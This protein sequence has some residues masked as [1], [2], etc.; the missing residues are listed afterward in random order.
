MSTHKFNDRWL[1]ERVVFPDSRVAADAVLSLYQDKTV[2][3]SHT[4]N[5]T[6]YAIV[7]DRA[8]A[9]RYDASIEQNL[10]TEFGLGLDQLASHHHEERLGKLKTAWSFNHC[11]ALQSWAEHLLSRPF[12]RPLIVRFDAH[13][14]LAAPMVGVTEAKGVFTAPVGGST[15]DLNDTSTIEEFVLRGF[16]G[17][18]SFIAPIL[19]TLPELDIVHVAQDHETAPEEFELVAEQTIETMFTGRRLCRPGVRLGP[20]SPQARFRYTRTSDAARALD[21]AAGRDHILDIDLDYFCNAFDNRKPLAHAM[22]QDA[23]RDETERL[24]DNFQRALTAS[25][26]V[27]S[28]VTLAL[29]PGFFPS[30]YW[31]ATV[32]RL[33]EIISSTNP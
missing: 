32:P 8:A 20:A 18:G 10:R 9:T 25:T 7:A 22:A 24:I 2:A 30:D 14:D 31:S 26:A 27:P 15:L 1:C 11:W 5:E 4:A 29:S 3:E 21:M 16:I 17:T 19:H 13:D 12:G 28:L 23:W 33:R 6:L